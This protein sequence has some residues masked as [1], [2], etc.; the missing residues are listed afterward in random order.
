MHNE[1]PAEGVIR[2]IRKKW[3][4]TMVRKRC[5]R[6]LWDYGFLWVTEIMSLTFSSAGSLTSS[7]PITGVT[8]E[9]HDISEYLDF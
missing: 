1:N 2:E 7:I 8:G 6:E 4:R 5:P 9:T 3:Y